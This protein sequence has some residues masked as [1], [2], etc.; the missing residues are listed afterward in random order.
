[1]IRPLTTF[2][3]L[4]AAAGVTL[5]AAGA[6]AQTDCQPDDIFCAEVRIG[7]GS[8]SVRVGP[9]DPGTPPV[10]PPPPPPAQPPT[11]IVET[12]PPPPP[13]PPPQ[14]PTVSVQPAP[15][16]PP[17]PVVV[18][19][20]PV[21]R[22]VRPPI[23][24]ERSTGL[25]LQLGGVWGD[26]IH[27]GG[28][29][30]AFRIR[31]VR[32]FAI[33]IGS[34]VYGGTDWNGFDRIEVPVTVDGLFFF[35]P[36]HRWQFYGV[37]SVGGSWAHVGGDYFSTLNRTYGYLGGAGGLGVEWRISRYFALNLDVRGFIRTRVDNTPGPEFVDASGRTS[38]TS[39]GGVTQ[40]GMTFYFPSGSGR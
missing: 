33:D 11:V 4:L 34:G 14:P 12:P 7:P 38:N 9:A 10:P 30:G 19:P 21:P 32:H 31:P 39:G 28:I 6:S 18:Q 20:M 26:G 36:Q 23:T 3:S 22:A 2:L 29:G 24:P 13:Q 40:F 25:H 8:G 27:L 35:N 1:M 37:L 5:L 16:P 17:A 15:P